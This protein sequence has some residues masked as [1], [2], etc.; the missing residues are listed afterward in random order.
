[1]RDRARNGRYAYVDD[2]GRDFAAGIWVV[3]PAFM[4]DLV[5][6]QLGASETTPARAREEAYF[7]GARRDDSELREAAA[8]LGE[9]DGGERVSEQRHPCCRQ[10]GR[11]P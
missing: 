6:E 2:R 11:Q 9:V 10:R 7:A 1:M 5:H 3:D 8:V 4:L